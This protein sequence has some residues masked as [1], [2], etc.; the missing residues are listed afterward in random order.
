MKKIFILFA[1]IPFSAEARTI[2]LP[3]TI[4]GGVNI[5]TIDSHQCVTTSADR[6]SPV[7]VI[8]YRDG[9]GEALIRYLG[10]TF[11]ATA[12]NVVVVYKGCRVSLY[13]YTIGSLC[14]GLKR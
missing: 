5:C 6:E 12:T 1:F 8:S 2:N 14:P 10:Q 9:K 11:V 13:S 3:G 7:K 4:A